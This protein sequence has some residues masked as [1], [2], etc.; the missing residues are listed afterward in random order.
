MRESQRQSIVASITSTGGS[1]PLTKPET[2]G[3]AGKKIIGMVGRAGAGKDTAADILKRNLEE[4][5]WN[6]SVSA[7]ASP[8]K[9]ALGLVFLLPPRHFHDRDLKE[10]PMDEL[11][12]R[13]PREL[14]QWFGTNVMRD[15][16]DSDI[17]L[18]RMW[19]FVEI[20]EFDTFIITDVR[21]MNE[22]K[23]IVEK[24]GKLIYLDADARLPKLPENA[25][26]S[27]LEQYRIRDT[28]DPIVVKNN[29]TLE[30]FTK[31]IQ[32]IAKSL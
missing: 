6:V 29:G 24:G 28:F 9:E 13:S 21:F 2:E 10:K 16:V 30:S 20:S 14:C 31:E 27:E 17:W 7:F 19:R 8:I 4:D 11:Y 3:M 32:E 22:A 18:N 1:A 15:G 25:H 23:S 5:G 12:G 26:V